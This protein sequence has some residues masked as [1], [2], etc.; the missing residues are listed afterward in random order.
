[1]SAK[2]KKSIKNDLKIFDNWYE[3]SYEPNNQDRDFWKILEFYLLQCPSENYNVQSRKIPDY[4]WRT[5]AEKSKLTRLLKNSFTKDRLLFAET[6]DEFIPLLANNPE[7]NQITSLQEIACI[8]SSGISQSE[9]IFA[10][11]R[12]SLA[13][14]SF[15]IRKSK[16]VVFY[17]LENRHKGILNARVIVTSNTLK[18]WQQILIKSNT[19]QSKGA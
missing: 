17:I 4:G 14:G 8:K 9:Q 7:V 16:S 18:A 2:L 6:Y 1:M 12:N 3:F 13:H 5:K 10:I 11:V 15:T 19:K